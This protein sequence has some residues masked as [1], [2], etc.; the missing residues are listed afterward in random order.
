M[1]VTRLAPE[2]LIAANGKPQ[3]GQFDGIPKQLAIEEF[4]YRNTMDRKASALRRYFHYKQFQFVSV[5]TDRYVIGVAIADIRYLGS[6]FCYVYDIEKNELIENNWLRPLNCGYATA[7]SPYTSFAHIASKQIQ[8][9]LF[10]GSW[11][12]K[13]NTKNIKADLTLSA[14]SGSLPLAMCTPTG[15]TGWTYTQKHNALSVQGSL[16]VDG[17]SVPLDSALAGYDFSA[18]Y[19]RR[20]TSWRWAS[21]NACLGE[22]TFGLNLAAGVNETGSCENVLWRNGERHFLS[23][24][25]FE[26]DRDSSDQDNIDQHW[27]V[28]SED[29]CVDL[30]FKPLNKRSEK[31]D[32]WLLKS[33]FRQ[34]VGQFSG[35]IKDNHGQ[36]HH[37][38]EVLGLTEDHFARW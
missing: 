3:Y 2:T 33:N 34:F 30:V 12:V 25:H 31:L 29:G 14:P 21:I 7:S 36:V 24:V 28:F 5:I 22:A 27:R 13:L 8:F 18:G 35:S 20:E 4:D 32:L 26:F 9:H 38:D 10:E 17:Q 37:L 23:N 6:A 16:A 1:I 11:Q 15:Y 19:M